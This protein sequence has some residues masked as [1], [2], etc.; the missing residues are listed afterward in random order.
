MKQL[1]LRLRKPENRLWVLPS[2]GAIFAII[3]ALGAGLSRYFFRDS[4][5]LPAV[6]AEALDGILTVIASSM[7]AVS[8]FAL[9]TMVAAFASA[10]NNASPRA[11][12]LV[13]N[14]DNTKLAI[15]SFI[16]AFVFAV[17]AKIAIGMGVFTQNGRFLLFIGTLIVLAYMIYMLIRW[18]YTMSRLGRMDN[19]IAKI[20]AATHKAISAYRTSTDF[21]ASG[22]RPTE[23]PHACLR[24]GEV[25]YLSYID[26]AELNALAES[27]EGHIHL[28]ERPGKLL[29]PQTVIAEIYAEEVSEAQCQRARQ[30]FLIEDTRSYAQD[31]RYG[32]IVLGEVGIRAMSPA[33]NDPGT[34]VMVM[35]HLTKL[36]VGEAQKPAE[37]S[38]YGALSVGPLIA[39]EFIDCGFDGL[40]RASVGDR[41]VN[42]RALKLLGMIYREGWNH[43][44]QQSAQ[45]MAKLI[46]ALNDGS[47]ALPADRSE[48]EKIYA[49]AFAE[50]A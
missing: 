48:L 18:V 37:R 3:L 23:A 46:L 1:W 14:D 34:A 31:P 36:L 4:A 17:I 21:A 50:S 25:G 47:Q 22:M 5:Y 27:L 49:A 19:T 16:S 35:N 33:V 30:C 43:Q 40:L 8:T 11:T 15:A 44:L 42:V 7:L 41:T 9:S 38:G 13:M 24:A 28:P 39:G 26:F 20:Y 32:L 45:T 29:S 2:I 10:S 12:E 6:N